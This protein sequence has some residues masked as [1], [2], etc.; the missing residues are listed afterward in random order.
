MIEQLEV[1]PIN[2]VSSSTVHH[3]LRAS[4][5]R[6]IL[7][8]LVDNLDQ[9]DSTSSDQS[10]TLT[11]TSETDVRE[12]TRTIVAIEEDIPP[13]HVSGQEYHNVRTA[14]CQTHLP[15]LEETGAIEFDPERKTVG[16]GPNLLALA[17]T[18]RLSSAVLK[19]IFHDGNSRQYVPGKHKPAITD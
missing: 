12:L 16:A 17:L 13:S 9:N 3:V 15:L 19:M 2:D 5:R 14:L 6:L 18:C 1:R 4:R 8:I 11:R 7:I 10:R